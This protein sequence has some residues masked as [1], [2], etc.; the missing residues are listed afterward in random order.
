MSDLTE[1][2]LVELDDKTSANEVEK[3]LSRNHSLIVGRITGLLFND[4]R[5]T[6]MPELGLDTSPIEL[7]QFS[8]S[9]TPQPNLQ[10]FPLPQKT[11]KLELN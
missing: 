5:F 1:S 3:M 6:V 11:V 2:D 8:R 9:H 7:K 10:R 4:K